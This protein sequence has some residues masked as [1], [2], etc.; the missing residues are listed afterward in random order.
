M[1]N[2]S[3]DYSWL[4]IADKDVYLNEFDEDYESRFVKWND[5]ADK[6]EVIEGAPIKVDLTKYQGRVKHFLPFSLD[7][8]LEDVFEEWYK[9]NSK[10]R[11]DVTL[12]RD[13]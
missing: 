10:R 5:D 2:H 8:S 12:T 7:I 9:L 11:S 13:D 1:A 3:E 6:Y 4:H